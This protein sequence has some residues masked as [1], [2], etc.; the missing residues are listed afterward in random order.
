MKWS[1]DLDTDKYEEYGDGYVLDKESNTILLATELRISMLLSIPYK[2][3]LGATKF[4]NRKMLIADN[5]LS[6]I[7]DYPINSI[8][9]GEKGYGGF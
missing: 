6:D 1:D 9:L 8:Y 2:Y 5:K 3:N 7:D 4:T